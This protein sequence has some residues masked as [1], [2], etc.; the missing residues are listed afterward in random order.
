MSYQGTVALITGASSG[1]GTEFARQWAQRGADVVLVARRLDRL[2]QLAA[3]L[4]AAHGVT[5][6]PIAADL[7]RP[8]AG[9]A[10]RAEVEARGIA[11]QTVINNAGFGGFGPFAKQDPDEIAR[12]IQLNV[13]AVTEVSRAFLPQLVADGR[14]ALVNVASLAAYQPAPNMAVYGATKAFV[15]SLTE[16]LAY[17]TRASS[18]RVLAVSPGATGTEFNDVVGQEELGMGRVATP[19]EIA[20]AT[21]QALERGNVPPSVVPG[22]TNKAMALA[23]RLLPRRAMLAMSGRVFKA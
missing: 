23:P 17:E 1:I 3:D 18:L 9:E 16:A 15:L 10:L 7:S 11:V 4:E 13:V 6:T 21:R 14:G 8:G 20:A 19:A 5:A 12:M 2:E 22:L